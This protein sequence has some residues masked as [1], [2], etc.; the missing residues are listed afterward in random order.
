M[1]SHL[2]GWEKRWDEQTKRSEIERRGM[3]KGKKK[4]VFWGIVCVR[5]KVC[6][7]SEKVRVRVKCGDIKGGSEV[8][9]VTVQ[10][11]TTTRGA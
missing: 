11:S 9:I 1:K 5:V 10:L 8:L 2:L 7:Q 3:G 4:C 6:A